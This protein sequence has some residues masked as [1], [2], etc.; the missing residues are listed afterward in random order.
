MSRKSARIIAQPVISMAFSTRNA[1]WEDRA[2]AREAIRHVVVKFFDRVIK[3]HYDD[4]LMDA[5]RQAILLGW[6][7]DNIKGIKLTDDAIKEGITNIVKSKSTKNYCKNNKIFMKFNE[8]PQPQTRMPMLPFGSGLE[9]QTKDDSV[10]DY[11][12]KIAKLV[13][14]H[15]EIVNVQCVKTIIKTKRAEGTKQ[16]EEGTKQLEEASELESI[17]ET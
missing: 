10:S 16:L 5:G 3:S 12:M 15:P 8:K 7:W 14:A 6:G 13:S 1:R 17:L 2:R 9:E 11:H 4:S